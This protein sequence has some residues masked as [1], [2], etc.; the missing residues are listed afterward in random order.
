MQAALVLARTRKS[1]VVYDDSAPP[2]NGASHGVH[3]VLG[4]DGLTPAEIRAQA[5]SQINVYNQ[6]ELREARVR[7]VVQTALGA[8]V[9]STE[10]GE[11][12]K[13]KKIILALGYNDEHPE[14]EGF[15]EAWADTI[16]SCPF[17]D[18]YENRDRVWAIVAN[19]EMQATHFPAMLQNWT[20]HIKLI[21]NNPDIELEAAFEQEMEA[22]QIPIHRGTILAIEQVDGKV[23]SV[24][25]D[26][27]A[28]VE[29]ETLLWIP[30][31]IRTPLEQRL[32]VNFDLPLSDMGL[33]Q[34]DEDQETTV[35]GLF[36]VGD[37]SSSKASAM[38]AAMAGSKAAYKIIKEWY[39]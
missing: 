22:R 10:D 14:I 21:L 3:N 8:F 19:S 5:W 20:S 30:S 27:E 24:L 15:S 26:T 35:K 25:L 9:V 13:A 29:V 2:R 39:S 32:I 6:A 31:R 28:R 1:I 12:V 7:D 11:Q 17:C 37:V 33:I 34:T 18:G 4:L 16:I 23:N 38:G 36:A